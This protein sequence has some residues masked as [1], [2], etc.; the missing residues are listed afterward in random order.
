MSVY[1]IQPVETYVPWKWVK[2]GYLIWFPL[3]LQSHTNGANWG[4]PGFNPF[5]KGP[6]ERG[7]HVTSMT[8]ST[9]KPLAAGVCRT[10]VK[11]ALRVVLLRLTVWECHTQLIGVITRNMPRRWLVV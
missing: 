7:L 11:N 1:I 5:S 6:R 3:G 2:L 10:S 8:H 9:C 4:K